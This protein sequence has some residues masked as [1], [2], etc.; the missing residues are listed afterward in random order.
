MDL[1]K[2]LLSSWN[3]VCNIGRELPKLKVLNLSENIL[4]IPESFSEKQTSS[5]LNL[6][7]L[8]LNR[9]QLTWEQVNSMFLLWCYNQSV[10]NKMNG[11]ILK[12][13]LLLADKVCLIYY[14]LSGFNSVVFPISGEE[15]ADEPRSFSYSSHLF[16]PLT[17]NLLSFF[18]IVLV[19][20]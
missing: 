4:D 5:F 15:G 16:S 8:I 14:I 19:I 2:N 17:Q 12:T 18:K 9:C 7:T 11:I 6:N 20:F 10:N 13:F 1:S 3:I